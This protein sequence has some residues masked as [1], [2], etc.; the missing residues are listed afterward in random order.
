MIALTHFYN[1][2]IHQQLR[3]GCSAA[4]TAICWSLEADS[5]QL[6]FWFQRTCRACAAADLRISPSFSERAAENQPAKDSGSK[7][8][9]AGAS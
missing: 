5:S 6:P 4:R 3:S 1:Q 9:K 2:S 8:V 7:K